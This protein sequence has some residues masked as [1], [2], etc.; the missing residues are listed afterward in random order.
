MFMRLAKD[1]RRPSWG[2]AERRTSES[3]R[4]ARSLAV[5]ERSEWEPAPLP[6]S[7]TLWASSMTMTSHHAFSR[8][9]RYSPSCLRVSMEMIDLS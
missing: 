4:D 2:V 8:W 6:R 1:S 3:E 5:R 9:V 7:A